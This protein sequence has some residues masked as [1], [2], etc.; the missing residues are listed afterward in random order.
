MTF[1]LILLT[2]TFMTFYNIYILNTYKTTTIG[3]TGS[4][5]MMPASKHDDLK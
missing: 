3:D 1:D 2:I 4:A 5:Y